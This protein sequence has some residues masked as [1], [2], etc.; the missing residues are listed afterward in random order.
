MS[1]DVLRLLAQADEIAVETDA[2]E[3]LTAI[4]YDV[5]LQADL[6]EFGPDA[7]KQW[8]KIVVRNILPEERWNSALWYVAK[9]GLHHDRVGDDLILTD[10]QA[11]K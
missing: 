11:D 10:P 5:G 1:D 6:E 3:Q 9:W 4:P 8:G 2:P 7:L